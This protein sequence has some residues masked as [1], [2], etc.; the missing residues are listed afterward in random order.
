MAEI[1]ING[2]T[3]M[4]ERAANILASG[5]KVTEK[6]LVKDLNISLS[7][8]NEWKS[9]PRFKV[10]VLQIFD[11]NVNVDRNVRYNRVNK[12]L[13]PVYKE[14][15]K[16]LSEEGALENVSIRELL[17]MMSRLHQELRIDASMDK[18]FLHAGIK[19]FDK[20]NSQVQVSDSEEELLSQVSSDYEEMR[21][22]N[23]NKKVVRLKA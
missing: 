1:K 16:R 17:N 6:S 12:Y 23:L 7:T 13:K 3:L 11:S 5:V 21:K 22:N 15:R 14:I 18:S 4:Q 2:L 20:E 19:E 10:R 9:D 8:L